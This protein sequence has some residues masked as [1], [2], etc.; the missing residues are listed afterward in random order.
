MANHSAGNVAPRVPK[1]IF[2]G[3]LYPEGGRW[4]GGRM[5]EDLAQVGRYG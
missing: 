2:G 4:R 1:E 3:G 5:Q